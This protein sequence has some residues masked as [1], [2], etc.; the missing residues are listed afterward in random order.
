VSAQTHDAVAHSVHDRL[1]KLAAR[2]KED[3]NALLAGYGNERILYRLSRTQHGKRFVLKGATLFIMW[4]GK[5]HRPT[6]DLDLLGSG[7]LDLGSL[8]A[9]FQDVCTVEV[10]P[11]GVRFDPASVTVGEIR[12]GQA[13]GGLRVKL[14]GH[15]GTAR[16][17]IQIDVGLGDT[18]TPAP[19]EVMFPT[20]L[21]MPGPK[22]KAYPR[23]T[24]IAEKLDAM[25][26][27]G[28]KNSRMKDYYDLALLSRHF[29]FD[30]AT[31]HAAIGATL[32]RRERGVP[33]GLPTGL[34][35]AFASDTAKATQWS[36]FIRNHPA[37]ELPNDLA[38][39][40]R[41]VRAFLEPPIMSLTSGRE[42][43]STWAPG[44]PWR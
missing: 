5:A 37:P 20:L 11:D 14:R 25:L 6:R 40:V 34:T 21:D 41:L 16:L 17:S 9:I 7:Q 3:F 1:L 26:E 35:D 33:P 18:I 42:F 13:Y 22:I 24:A 23:E 38:A 30:G 8:Q 32:R 19:Q 15:M 29:A 43:V 4:L 39:V 31:L 2:R 10:E 12:E 28:I 27:L 44:G 36:A